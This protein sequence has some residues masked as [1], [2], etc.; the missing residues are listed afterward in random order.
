MAKTR[1]FD[2]VTYHLV[3]AHM[4]KGQA[5]H[6]ADYVRKHGGLARVV[7]GIGIAGGCKMKNCWL[8]YTK[9]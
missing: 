2:G 1:K 3:R 4:Y 7:P 6:E 9:E 8:V 5:Q